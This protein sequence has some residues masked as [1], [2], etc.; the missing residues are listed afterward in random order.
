MSIL[1]FYGVP[2][3]N[4]RAQRFLEW[5]EMSLEM[6]PLFQA[7]FIDRLADLLCTGRPNGPFRLVKPEALLFK[8]QSA[9]VQ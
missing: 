1:E 3:S 8:I 6:P 7:F 9:I 4:F 5:V 2:L